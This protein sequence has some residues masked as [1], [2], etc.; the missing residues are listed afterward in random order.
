MPP[1]CLRSV[2]TIDLNHQETD[3]EEVERQA[4]LFKAVRELPPTRRCVIELRFVE[5]KSIWDAAEL[6]NQARAP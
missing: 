6:L 4:L 1:D 2:S 3:Y 5:Q